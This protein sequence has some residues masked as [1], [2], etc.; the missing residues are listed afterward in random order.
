MMPAE[1]QRLQ[2]LWDR[3]KIVDELWRKRADLALELAY[4]ACD[5]MR[6]EQAAAERKEAQ[7]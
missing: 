1:R 3:Q 7:E 5:M 2:E 4:I 6:I